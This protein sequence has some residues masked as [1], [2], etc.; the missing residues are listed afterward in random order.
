MQTTNKQSM[1]QGHFFLAKNEKKNLDNFIVAIVI[2]NPLMPIE[3][4]EWSIYPLVLVL[5]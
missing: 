4:D 5:A 1:N 3:M 2:H